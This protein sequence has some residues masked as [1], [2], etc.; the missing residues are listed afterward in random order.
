MRH[1][2]YFSIFNIFVNEIN[3]LQ[4]L[5]EYHVRIKEHEVR[6]QYLTKQVMKSQETFHEL[7]RNFEATLEFSKTFLSESKEVCTKLLTLQ[8]DKKV[9]RLLDNRVELETLIQ[10]T[11][12]F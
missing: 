9:P 3:L 11:K 1:F 7:K 2:L 8:N 10:H 6:E 5:A 12:L 4:K